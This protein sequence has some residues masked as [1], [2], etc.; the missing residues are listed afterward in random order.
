MDWNLQAKHMILLPTGD[1]LVW[2]TG[3]NASVWH[4]TTDGSFTSVPYF[5][6][7]LHCAAQATAADG[8][9]VVLGGQG[10]ATHV[11]I[12]VTAFFDAFTNTWTSGTDMHH[13]RWYGSVT[14]LPDGRILATSGDDE[15]TNRV[16][17]PEIYDPDTD[18][19]TQLPGATRS[20]LALYPFIY[21]LP[22]GRIFEA[23]TKSSTYFY[24]VA[25]AG[26][27]IDGPQNSWGT[28]GYSESGCMYRPGQII[29]MGGGDPAL[30]Q[31]AVI[32]MNDANPQFRDIAPMNFPR[33]RHDALILLDGQVLVVGGTTDG[34]NAAN[35]ILEP[36][37][38]DPDT[39]TWNVMAP[40]A[41]ARM[42]HSS[43]VLLPDGRVVAGGGEAAGRQH[44]E[45]YSPPYLFK[46]PRPVIS[47]APEV[48]AYGT[49]FP[50][51]S[52]EF[53][54]IVSVAILRPSGSTH[55]I[56]YNQRYVPLDFTVD[57]QTLLVDAPI[58]SNL[59]PPGLYLLTIK[60]SIGVP[61]E[62]TW[63]KIG[64]AG[65]LLPGDLTGRVLDQATGLGI[66]NATIDYTDSS[67][68]SNAAGEY[69]IPGLAAGSHSFTVS[70]TGY[71]TII[72]SVTV[73][74]GGTATHDFILNQPGSVVGRVI[75]H[76]TQQPI[77]GATVVYS[78]GT[79]LTDANGNYTIDEIASGFQIISV[80]APFY[81]SETASTFVVA[82]GTVIVDFHLH[83]A[84]TAIEGEV[85]DYVTGLP[86]EGAT[87]TYAGNSLITNN[88]GFYFF[89]D[90]PGGAYTVTASAPG[91][92][93]SS[94]DVL[95]E[96][97][98]ETTA[99]F[100]LLPL[101][102]SGAP[103]QLQQLQS[104][105]G[106]LGTV[107][108]S[109]DMDAVVGALYVAAISTKPF[110]PPTSV[111]GMNLNWKRVA[112]QC[113]G[114]DSTGI[115]V[116]YA[117]G[118]QPVTGS[119]TANLAGTPTN[120]VITVMRYS[121]TIG[122]GDVITS[123]TNGVGGS[124]SGGI[125]SAGYQ[126]SLQADAGS[127]VVS[128]VGRRNRDHI[129]GDGFTA[130]VDFETGTGGDIAGLS[131]A[132]KEFAQATEAA[133]V[134][135][136]F[137]SAT[138]WSV[139]AFEL[140][141]PADESA[142]AARFVGTPRMGPAP[143]T[144]NF[145]DQSV[146]APQSWLW[147]F[148]DG[149]TS[150][151]QNPQH[152][153]QNPGL[154]SVS[155]TT[156]YASGSSTETK[157]DYIH[158]H[159]PVLSCQIQTVSP[160][161][162]GSL[163]T[164]TVA[165]S[166]G[167]GTYQYS[168][169]F[170]DGTPEIAAGSASQITHAFDNPGH[171]NV[172]ATVSDGATSSACSI[173][174]TVHHPIVNGE[175]ASSST[176]IRHPGTNSI[177]NV[178]PDNNSVTAI[179][180]QSLTMLFEQPVGAH[181]SSLAVAPDGNIWVVER[182]AASISVLGPAGTPLDSLSL[183]FASRPG[184]IAFAP[185]G[186]MAYVTAEATGILYAI[187]PITRTVVSEIAVGPMPRGIAISADSER[188]FVTRFISPADHGEVT[189]VSGTTLAPVRTF[190]LAIDP[191]PDSEASGRGVPNY[192]ITATIN[193][194]GR[195]LWVPS[196]K[197]NVE[198]GLVRDGIPLTFESTVRTIVSQIDLIANSEALSDRLD[199][200]DRDM[201]I[202]VL[203]SPLGD[204]AFVATQGT[205]KVDIVDAYS[206]SL[207]T[208]L[209]SVGL[210][211][212][213]MA[214]GS[215]GNR[216][217]VHSFLSRSVSVWDVSDVV[218]ANGS[219]AIQVAE[220]GTVAN[221]LLASDVLLGKRIFYNADD[222]RMNEDGYLSCAS[223]HL[224]GDS[225]G[226]VFDFT[227]RGEGLRNT[228]TLR[229]RAGTGHGR[230]HWSANFD[231]VQ[232]FEHDIRGPFR[233]SGFMADGDFFAGTRSQPLGDPKIGVSVELDA[234][235]AYVESLD[236]VPASPYRLAGGAMTAD[237]LAG[238][239][240][241]QQLGCDSCHLGPDFTDSSLEVLHDVGTIRATSGSRLGG[242]LT[243]IDTPTLL[244]IWN[245]APYLHDGSASTLLDVL[246][247]SNPGEAHGS[248]LSLSSVE[249]D[250]LVAYLN[251]IDEIE[252]ATIVPPQIAGF[253][254]SIGLEGGIVEITG[255]G[256]QN[257]F[258]VDFGGVIAQSFTVDSATRIL[259]TVPPGAASG[260]IRIAAPSGIAVSASNFTLQV[261]NAA[262]V[263]AAG[264]DLAIDLPNAAVLDGTVT[265]DGLPNPPGSVTT[266]WSM[267]SGPATGTV[268]FADAT[269][270]DTTATFSTEG[271]YVLRL[272]ASDG[273]FSP[274]DELTVTVNGTG[275]GSITFL[276]IQSGGSTAVDSVATAQAIDFGQG[277]LYVA[278]VSTK[279]YRPVASVS[280][281]GATWA[282]VSTQCSARSQTGVSLWVTSS[283]SGPGPVTASLASAPSNA[284]ISVV[285]YSGATGASL[286]ASA[287][288]LG[289]DAAALCDGGIDNA[290][291]SVGY[292][293]SQPGSIILGA[294][295]MRNRDHFPGTSIT[296]LSQFSSG[297]GGDI[298]GLAIVENAAG[299]SS[300]DGTFNGNVDWSMVAVEIQSEPV[301]NEAP[302]VA[303]GAD[304][305]IDLPNAALLDGTVTDD[306]LPNPP[307]SV[308]TTWSMTSGPATGT[309]T[310]ANA[311]AVDTT[312]TFSIEGVY[313]LRLTASDGEFSSFDELTVTVNAVPVVSIITPEN[314]AAFIVGELITFSASAS[315]KEDGDL[316]TQISWFSHR[317]GF[318]GQ[319][320]S[321]S[322]AT[323]D[324]G[325]HQITAVVVD[326]GGAEGVM[327]IVIRMK[328]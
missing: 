135:G 119:V 153:Y 307:A 208:T 47:I 85:L 142:P 287:N 49:T 19:W 48:A 46:G 96:E 26:S 145:T 117:V 38:W 36:E 226:R 237:G 313:V 180:E 327:E 202:D 319:G 304:Q 130:V 165:S 82:N 225:D 166:G 183:A 316:S 64:D 12:P 281:L 104:G 328:N 34:D 242:P 33:R 266:T 293:A 99:D 256:F 22:D 283:A 178:N 70:A 173:V 315:D 177:W 257:V 326:S 179:D 195:R 59:A 113:G 231:E 116:W 199:L 210:A 192:L 321:I 172:T 7:D 289:I 292:S 84:H 122:I 309:V 232:D 65:D 39:E 222:R 53:A 118:S 8:R 250:Q 275:G 324:K 318:L 163:A 107:S 311:S 74:A 97:G 190:S 139:I 156:T 63:I 234:L 240:L 20:S 185:D 83:E 255:S 146:G 305:A 5:A 280:G 221:E 86:I 160:I 25:G 201:A 317:S 123:N 277:D 322:V 32:N 297:A 134:D 124:C 261:P 267:T 286:R 111:T 213:G 194:D 294:I 271:V 236:E 141:F 93:P 253:T 258:R 209:N 219:A 161:T 198:R 9:I 227:D 62:A 58:D 220:V 81:A 188:I 102:G 151:Q 3:D 193:P 265:D 140:L 184:A 138:D 66:A 290:A 40:M 80:S 164:F 251:Q 106:S 60:N 13:G 21:V 23:G 230:V 205:N 235:A 298:A 114:R 152:I 91:Y 269:A 308:T 296:E 233:G 211:P 223:C 254:P 248:T 100:A 206:G 112:S 282:E 300:L 2:S 285:R 90:V 157:A 203:F 95:V 186:S 200:N 229:G 270:V 55:G 150:I 11:G 252:A 76:V 241:F 17:V 299:S 137:S 291:Y 314:D 196:K 301:V 131:V 181:P 44:A 15:S 310:F 306:G 103:V 43:T 92:F 73:P 238:K 31:A 37:L 126:L 35:A 105:V 312:A 171:F 18:T 115:D 57:G 176:I 224:D 4:V 78:G 268:T 108:T 147:N 109:G 167:S 303:A 325:R 245:D 187:D 50:I 302:V 77:A 51:E 61:S 274:F 239:A 197:D 246:T 6:G 30:T 174:Q 136:T 75:D 217:F 110:T 42:Y 121:G 170:G 320:Q 71:A 278:A 154:Y 263:V 125:D 89:D 272:T 182:D 52:A 41:E 191:G 1:V 101:D 16:L 260:P 14:T 98:F 262:P 276:E 243:G 133:S 323:L 54:D 218:V 67:V 259:A 79:V 72:E 249:L 159:A 175:P 284:V 129:A 244:G 288:T 120:S 149:A 155:L 24:D 94:V 87:V 28:N 88:L 128:A 207:V 295:G 264:A 68:V 132:T 204:Y 273:E 228:I 143:L 247:T 168:W 189:E 279:P 69:S 56:D 10:S 212:Q 158:V 162:V 45:I 148:G 27:V 215:D 214:F 29:R 216:L 144:V 127:I 169:N